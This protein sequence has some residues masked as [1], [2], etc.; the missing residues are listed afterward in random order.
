MCL[1]QQAGGVRRRKKIK[2]N[3][4]VLSLRK[5]TINPVKLKQITVRRQNEISVLLDNSNYE[6]ISLH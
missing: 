1:R 3:N 5:L 6:S 2:V 4:I